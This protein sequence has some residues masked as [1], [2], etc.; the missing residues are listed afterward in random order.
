MNMFSDNAAP[1]NDDTLGGRISFAREACG[2]SAEEAA[3]RLGVLATSWSAW[4]CDR[5]VPRANRLT[6]MAG[7]LGVS[8]SWLLTGFGHGP[9]EE[10][11]E[12]GQAALREELRQ[13]SVDVEVLNRRLRTIAS[14]LDA[15][16]DR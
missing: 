11:S 5:D 6:M 7:V 13:A 15:R 10:K 12:D 9:L 1:H 14:H 4:E 8:P 3:E 16:D 2:L